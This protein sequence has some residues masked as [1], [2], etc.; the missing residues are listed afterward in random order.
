MVEAGPY[1]I[2]NKRKLGPI[3]IARDIRD[4]RYVG[5]SQCVD[6]DIAV[7]EQILRRY[8]YTSSRYSF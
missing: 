8:G 1:F 7:T 4:V 5:L 2:E 6:H 3:V